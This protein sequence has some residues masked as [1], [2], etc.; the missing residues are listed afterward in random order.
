MMAPWLAV[1][2]VLV[3]LVGMLA[4]LKIEQADADRPQKGIAYDEA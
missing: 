1:T 2:I 4:I 3:A